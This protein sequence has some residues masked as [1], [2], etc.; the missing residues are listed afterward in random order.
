MM[1][2]QEPGEQEDQKCSDMFCRL[3]G[4]VGGGLGS[5]VG[6]RDE[7]LDGRTGG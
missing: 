5:W 4:W 7:R 1:T 2:V 3:D 6:R